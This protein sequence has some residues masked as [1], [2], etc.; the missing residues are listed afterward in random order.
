MN[1]M[2]GTLEERTIKFCDSL[3]FL[4]WAESL[5]YEPQNLGSSKKLEKFEKGAVTI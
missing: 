1:Y 5:K 4:D 2:F 3:L